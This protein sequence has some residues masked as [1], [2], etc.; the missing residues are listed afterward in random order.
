M[1]TT[2][3]RFGL[4]WPLASRS[5]RMS[6]VVTLGIPCNGKKQMQNQCHKDAN[7]NNSVMY[8][9]RMAVLQTKMESNYQPIGN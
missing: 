4:S 7:G 2:R 5:F 3:A 6:A 1:I 9:I 8:V